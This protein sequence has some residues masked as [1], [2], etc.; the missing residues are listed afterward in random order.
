[1]AELLVKLADNPLGGAQTG[2]VINVQPDGHVW[3][4]REN[5]EV[6]D[7]E[8]RTDEHSAKLGVLRL[9]GV[10]VE[11]VL[12]LLDRRLSE[13]DPETGEVEVL[14]RRDVRLN[15]DRT[16]AFAPSA[17][18]HNAGFGDVAAMSALAN[19]RDEIRKT[20]SMSAYLH[21]L[22]TEKA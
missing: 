10:P 16:P 19:V 5:K 21:D 17:T 13:P 11:D 1:M 22:V 8:G 20:G 3:G 15:L 18:F 14:H 6:W 9:P 4:R 7:A 2:W 12:Y